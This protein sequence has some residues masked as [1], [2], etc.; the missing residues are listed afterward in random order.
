M[1]CGL[2]QNFTMRWSN[3]LPSSV[4]PN[5]TPIPTT[6]TTIGECVGLVTAT[7]CL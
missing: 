3:F 4:G 5:S 1:Q 2:V 7:V 6:A